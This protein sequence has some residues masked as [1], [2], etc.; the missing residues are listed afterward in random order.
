MTLPAHPPASDSPRAT[1]VMIVDDSIVVRGFAS[2]WLQQDGFAIVGAFANGRVAIEMMPQA[3]PDIV[4]LDIDMPELDGLATLPR[5]LAI[6]PQL[7][8]VVIST[9]TRRNAELS[10][11]C[12]ARGAIDCL[13]KPTAD[14]EVANP[15]GFRRELLSKLTA[16]A[17]GRGLGR[18][19]EVHA[20]RPTPPARVGS[21]RLASLSDVPV[22]RCLLIGAS[23][24]GPQAVTEVLRHLGR[25]ARTLPILVVQHMPPLFTAAFADRLSAETGLPA[26]EA[27]HGDRIAAGHVYVAP[28]GRHMGITRSGLAIRLSDGPLIEHCRPAVD[29][30]FRE[31]AAAFGSSALAVILTGM[32]HDGTAGARAL[33]AAGSVVL[34]QDEATSTIWGMPG[35]VSRAGLARAVLP[36]G[37]IASAID[38][39]VERTRS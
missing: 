27:R 32:G 26:H 29:V 30:L 11:E 14:D 39:I 5:L 28:G 4:L 25:A 15:R 13:S 3:Q 7:A 19:S 21:G 10:L 20:A 34:A 24:G 17:E 18:Q 9:L 35:S 2:R 1:R 37:G 38:R 36:L 31:A 23:T 33:V 12:L 8:V 16:L 6:D 22:P